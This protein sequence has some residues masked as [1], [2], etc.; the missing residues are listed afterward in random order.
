MRVNNGVVA[1][2]LIA[3]LVVV[4]VD[5]ALARRLASG[6]G[7]ALGPDEA[8]TNAEAGDIFT[9][10][11]EE[12]FGRNT[13]AV[14]IRVAMEI[15]GG[16]SS[17]NF[18]CGGNSSGIFETREAMETAG[19]T[20]NAA[21]RSGLT[22]FDAPV[23]QLD[24][25]VPS[26]TINTVNLLNSN[27]ISGNGGGLRVT[28]AGAAPRLSSATITIA[29]SAFRPNFFNAEPVG[30]QGDGGGLFLDLDNASQLTISDS[31]FKDQTAQG[32]GGGFAVI[33]R[34]GSTVTLLRN[35]IEGNRAATCGGGVI[36]I[37]SGTV[38]LRDNVFQNNGADGEVADLCIERAEGA[39]G[40]AALYLAGNTFSTDGLRIDPSI[41]VFTE[42]LFLPVLRR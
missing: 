28:G 39:T 14:V 31:L 37:H 17:P 5:L 16:W 30:V 35:L 15:E 24:E 26:L 32:K 11:Y 42:Q 19:L 33:V 9:P 8:I 2:A 23:L 18:D 10:L 4:T 27:V 36:T 21:N 29:N 6:P 25:A 34:G 12:E 20:F 3:V 40:T 41:T 38:I 22:A 1:M 7:C 13:N